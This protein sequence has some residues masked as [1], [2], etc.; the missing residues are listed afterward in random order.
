MINSRHAASER[1][2]AF[3]SDFHTL[4]HD[5]RTPL[6]VIN[7]YAELL[8]LN[9]GLDSTQRSYVEAILRASKS[10][11]NTVLEHLEREESERH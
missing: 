7:G 11:Q 1:R 2:E 4:S 3:T 5:I 9:D 8:L 10:L 6:H